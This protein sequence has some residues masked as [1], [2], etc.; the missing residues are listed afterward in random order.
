ML[1]PWFLKSRTGQRKA[2][3]HTLA[4]AY[5]LDAVTDVERDVFGDHLDDCPTCAQEVSE[6]LATAA[7]LGSALAVIPHETLHARVFT[8]VAGT[9]QRSSSIAKVLSFRRSATYR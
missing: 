7:R 4:G 5:V 9:R 6:F 3:I 2:E 1:E 8:E